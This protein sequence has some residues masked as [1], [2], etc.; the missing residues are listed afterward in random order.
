MSADRFWLL[1]K[2]LVSILKLLNELCELI[3]M[4]Y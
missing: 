3:K 2:R 1:V 4:F